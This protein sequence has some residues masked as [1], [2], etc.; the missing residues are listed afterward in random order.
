MLRC[1]A[2]TIHFSSDKIKDSCHLIDKC[3]GYQMSKTDKK[4]INFMHVHVGN[5]QGCLS[6]DVSFIIGLDINCTPVKIDLRLL[7]Y[8]SLITYEGFGCN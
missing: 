5:N 7:S 4:V 6:V 1:F 2:T 8:V 3:P